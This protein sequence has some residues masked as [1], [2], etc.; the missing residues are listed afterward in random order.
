M[1]GDAS[2]LCDL[3]EDLGLGDFVNVDCAA[4]HHIALLTSE[5]LLR[6]GLNPAAKVLDLTARFRCR[7]CGRQGRAIISIKWRTRSG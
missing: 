6:V 2:P 5:T 1:G 3:Y 4:C 7:G